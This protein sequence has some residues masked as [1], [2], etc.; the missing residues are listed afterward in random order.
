M[1]GSPVIPMYLVIMS[2]TIDD[3]YSTTTSEDVF[4]NDV[5]R[6]HIDVTKEIMLDTFESIGR[7]TGVVNTIV[8]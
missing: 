6:D 2:V 7:T 4:R 3:G 5:P 8:A 1:Q